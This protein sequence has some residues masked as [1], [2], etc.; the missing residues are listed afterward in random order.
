MFC[1]YIALGRSVA[2][3][4][5]EIT[6]AKARG[7]YIRASGRLHSTKVPIRDVLIGIQVET[8][9]LGGILNDRK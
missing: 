2:Y 7:N 5:L 1:Y 3:Y 6:K 8:L 4:N 9:V